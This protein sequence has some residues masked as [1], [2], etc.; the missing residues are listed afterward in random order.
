[1]P[2][3]R[4]V[5]RQATWY[6]K[7][8]PPFADALARVRRDIRQHQAC[9]T[10]PSA[11]EEELVKVPRTLLA[12]FT[13]TLCYV[14]CMA[15]VEL[16]IVPRWLPTT[17]GRWTTYFLANRFNANSTIMCERSMSRLGP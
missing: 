5:I 3:P 11:E 16:G 4:A 7:R 8:D 13:E 17:A 12:T 9:S 15:S 14:A 2:G 10:S 6:H 1:M